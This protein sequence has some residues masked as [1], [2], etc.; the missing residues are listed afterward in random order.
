MTW[1]EVSKEYGFTIG[2][3]ESTTLNPIRLMMEEIA[4]VR[5]D[6]D[7]WKK[8]AV[9]LKEILEHAIETECFTPGSSTEGWAKAVIEEMPEHS[10]CLSTLKYGKWS[11]IP[12]IRILELLS[13][14]T[15]EE[16]QRCIRAAAELYRDR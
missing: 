12:W 4:T 15:K 9:E 10:G 6:I 14:M 11:R 3:F 2:V 5:A 8:S 16:R 7:A 1:Q 13:E